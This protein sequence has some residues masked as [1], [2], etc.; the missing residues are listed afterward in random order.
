MNIWG[1][2]SESTGI[3]VFTWHDQKKAVVVVK[4]F[5]FEHQ[6]QIMSC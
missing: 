6:L 4:V 1:S 5:T 3:H 2:E